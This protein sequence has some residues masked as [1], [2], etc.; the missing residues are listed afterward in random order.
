MGVPE[1]DSYRGGETELEEVGGGRRLY[2]LFYNFKL[3]ISG[4]NEM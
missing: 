3:Y 4:L 2:S 1:K